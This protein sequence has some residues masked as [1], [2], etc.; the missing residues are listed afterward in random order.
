MVTKKKSVDN[1]VSFALVSYILGIVAI[2]EAIISPLAGVVFAIIGLVFAKKENSSLARRANKL[3]II[4]LVIGIIFLVLIFVI[5][6]L[7]IPQ[8]SGF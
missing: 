6:Y 3:N 2:V 5:T 1:K 4:A 7:Q 8:L